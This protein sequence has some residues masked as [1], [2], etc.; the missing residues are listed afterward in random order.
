MPP[1]QYLLYLVLILKAGRARGRSE[2]RITADVPDGSSKV[3]SAVSVNFEGE[4]DR[5][6]QLVNQMHMLLS[7]EGLYWF[8]VEVGGQ[9][10][11]RL[12]LRVV[13]HRAVGGVAPQGRP[14]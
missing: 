2:V 1:T 7:H 14:A 10:I 13:Y 4:D 8:R 5:G 12:P 9:E 6:V 11:T 3:A